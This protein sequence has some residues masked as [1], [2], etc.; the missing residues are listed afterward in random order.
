MCVLTLQLPARKTVLDLVTV[1]CLFYT[2][3]VWTS[4]FSEAVPYFIC[5]L[6]F[7][8]YGFFGGFFF[9]FGGHKKLL[10]GSLVP[11]FWTCGDVCPGFQNQG[12]SFACPC[13]QWIP[14]I[15]LWPDT[16]LPLGGQHHSGVFLWPKYLANISTSIG[17]AWSHNRARWST[18]FLTSQTLRFSVLWPL[19]VSELCSLNDLR[20]YQN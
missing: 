3:C 4:V 10:V 11:L 13:V 9:Y 14:Q 6:T 5:F 18:T 19:M 16:F 8:D 7:V 12:G 1:T 20:N 17:G 2:L 15:R